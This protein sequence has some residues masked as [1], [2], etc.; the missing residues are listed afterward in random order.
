ML[1]KAQR[2]SEG[3]GK[4]IEQLGLRVR[5]LNALRRAGIHTFEELVTKTDLDLM[6]LKN[7]GETSLN[8]VTTCLGRFGLSLLSRSAG[9]VDSSRNVEILEALRQGVARV[10]EERLLEV[11]R[12][13]EEREQLHEVLRPLF[14]SGAFNN[15]LQRPP[16]LKDLGIDPGRFQF[17]RRRWVVEAVRSRKTL[18]EIGTLLGITRER[19]RQINSQAGGLPPRKVAELQMEA[20]K[21]KLAAERAELVERVRTDAR[22]HPGSTLNE[23]TVR[24]G[25][26]ASSVRSLLSNNEKKYLLE[27]NTDGRF[28][29]EPVWSDD[30][31]IGVLRE[32]ATYAFP[33]TTLA[34]SSLVEVGEIDG[35]SVA[36]IHN[37]FGSWIAACEA[38]SVEPGQ[39]WI[40]GYQSRWTDDDVY[41]YVEDYLMTSGTTGTFTDFDQWVKTEPG[42]PS[43]ALVRIRIGGWVQ[44]K[45]EAIKRL[46]ASG[47]LPL[48]ED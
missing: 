35:P 9:S 23:I 48:G 20:N 24:T 44:V 36:T 6:G 15:N 7:F 18:E 33:C 5:S 29:S 19:V 21:Q 45:R 42:A 43:G 8:D 37:R 41:R 17:H 34:Y 46:V 28:T 4:P 25:V 32:A 11:A 38:A 22:C 16:L 26:D 12:V 40:K 31:I 2:M 10:E 27:E 14:E 39:S 47:L 1:C 3:S 13:E 30:D